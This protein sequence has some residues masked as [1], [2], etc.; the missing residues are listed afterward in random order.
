M[1]RP[2]TGKRAGRQAKGRG[3][4]HAGAVSPALAHRLSLAAMALVLV[5][6]CLPRVGLGYFWDD[7]IFLTSGRANPL[8]FVLPNPTQTIFYRPIS[9]GLYFLGLGALGPWGAAV[10]HLL[11]LGLL[12]AC[13]LLLSSLVSKVAGTWAGLVAGFAFA[14]L[15]AMPEL[16][17]W[18]TT[19]QDI[20]AILFL[21]IAFHLRHEGRDLGAAIA[22]ACALLS[23]ETALAV[24]PAL[25][26]WPWLLGRKP[27]RL[28]ISAAYLG[29][30]AALWAS[31]H[32]GVH[33]FLTHGPRSEATGYVH[34][35]SWGHAPLHV[36]RYLLVL[37]NVP[38]TGYPTA[39]PG[40]LTPF[41]VMAAAVLLVGLGI[42]AGAG[43]T[44]GE[45]TPEPIPLGRIAGLAA[46]IALP[47]L[48]LDTAL[49]G[50]WAPYYTCLPGVGVALLLGAALSRV[51]R[52]LAVGAL[53]VFLFLGVRCRGIDA[54]E[55]AFTEA[56]T[57]R[58][59]LAVRVVEKGFRELRPTMPRGAEL[60]ISVAASGTLGIY[61]TIH[62]GQA[63]RVWYG[64]PTL[65][66]R[67]PER[68]QGGRPALLFRTTSFLSV[69]EIQPDS[70]GYEWAGP[71]PP[72]PFEIAG[73]IRSY[74]RGTAACGGTEE[75]LRIL[76]SLSAQE[77]DTMR[78]YDRRLSAL[79]LLAGG[80]EAEAQAILDK[81]PAF[82]PDVTAAM[83]RKLLKESTGRAVV[84]SSLFRAF[85]MSR[86]AYAR[87][88][89]RIPPMVP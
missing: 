2:T 58:G 89:T 53:A 71:T 86:E 38:L 27:Y 19:S 88:V 29:G 87:T 9:M 20:F 39:W 82:P 57:V 64:D 56:N 81:T 61:Q 69:V 70:L 76:G 11:N 5:I 62:Q 47:P 78:T 75:A 51:P 59:S 13:V 17:A 43:T 31:V 14:G 24:F 41:A 49:V 35:Q 83:I 28:G 21:L 66:A 36:L 22:A 85:G 48:L 42:G 50:H 68:R 60:L 15:A 30:V 84:D 67:M 80:R 25:L 12:L 79:V 16:V 73:P 54:P 37:F 18:I 46:L 32:P 1:K 74:T 33:A 44:P 7:Y 55:L 4:K 65:D 72:E 45:R 10:G 34:L 23:K 26:L 3:A 77:P 8:A 52:P 40:D 6:L 63:P